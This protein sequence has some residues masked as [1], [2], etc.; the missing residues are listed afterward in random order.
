MWQE[1]LAVDS[2]LSQ[3]RPIMAQDK[4]LRPLYLKR[5]LQLLQDQMAE[6]PTSP[7]AGGVGPMRNKK[8]LSLRVKLLKRQFGLP[9][10]VLSLKSLSISAAPSDYS[11][12][13]MSHH[14]MINE[15]EPYLLPEHRDQTRYTYHGVHHIFDQHREAI[16]RLKFLHNDDH[17]FVCSSMDG[18]LSICDLQ[19]ASFV[20][21]PGHSEGVVDFDIS[22]S[23]QFIVSCSLDGSLILW[24]LTKRTQLR[25]VRD[26][27]GSSYLYFCRFL[28]LNNNLIVCGVSSGV[29]RL[30]NISTGKFIQDGSPMLGKSLSVEVN[31]QGSLLW[32]G[33]DRGNIE[34]FRLMNCKKGGK[35]QKGSRASLG[36][37]HPVTSLAMRNSVSKL[38]LGPVLLV[39]LGTNH[40]HLFKITNEFGSLESLMEFKSDLRPS[41][42]CSLFAPILSVREGT[43]VVGGADDGTLAFF[44]LEK[45]NNAGRNSCVNKLQ[46]HSKPVISLGFSFNENFLASADTSG[47]IIV[48]KK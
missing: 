46:G 35:I 45:I 2:K 30:I 48:W 40:L 13:M 31:Q 17:T 32:V 26:F 21:L 1:V 19:T 44:D 43:C 4:D 22:E 36:E 24:D 25:C 20:T 16:T 33:N 29:V 23:N 41:L 5:R 18:L 11:H 9:N 42:M 27:E 10:D 12:S 39:N 3:F 15:N 7:S 14:D 47:Q 28:P 8:Y 38:H 6:R 37:H 34:S